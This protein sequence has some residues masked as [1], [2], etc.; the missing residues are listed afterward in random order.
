MV[1]LFASLYVQYIQDQTTKIFSRMSLH[2]YLI[3]ELSFYSIYHKIYC[4]VVH[5][6]MKLLNDFNSKTVL[7]YNS[8]TYTM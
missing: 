8:Y 7:S 6:I 3:C 5:Y 4:N 2:G 1:N